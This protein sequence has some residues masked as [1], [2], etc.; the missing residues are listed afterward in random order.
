M[1]LNISKKRR[2][3]WRLKQHHPTPPPHTHLHQHHICETGETVAASAVL[4]FIIRRISPFPHILLLCSLN[5]SNNFITWGSWD[6][7]RSPLQS[8]KLS[9]QQLV[10]ASWRWVSI[11]GPG[12]FQPMFQKSHESSWAQLQIGPIISILLSVSGLIPAFLHVHIQHALI[13]GTVTI[14]QYQYWDTGISISFTMSKLAF[15]KVI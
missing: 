6:D 8:L 13:L 5:G 10:R 4:V 12:A 9:I 2:I 1:T 7:L 3:D 11:Y 14:Y 15:S